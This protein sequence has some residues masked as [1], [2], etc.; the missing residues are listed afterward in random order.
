M[1][2]MLDMRGTNNISDFQTYSCSKS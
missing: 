2:L 1:F